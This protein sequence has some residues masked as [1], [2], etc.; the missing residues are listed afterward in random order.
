MIFV[1]LSDLLHSIIGSR[2]IHLI[3]TDSN[4]LLFTAEEYSI[5]YIYHS[6]PIHSS[7]DEHLGSF[8]VLAVIKSTVQ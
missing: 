1:F 6:F 4:A 5:V 7:V 8:L 2:F 3:R